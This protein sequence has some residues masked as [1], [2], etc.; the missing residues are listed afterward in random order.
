MKKF[1]S[2]TLAIVFVCAAAFPCFAKKAYKLEMPSTFT[3]ISSEND[4]YIWENTKTKSSIDTILSENGARLFY[5]GAD[6]A[7]QKSFTD[8][9]V[10]KL[11]EAANAN[12]EG[13]DYTISYNNV[14]FG[15]RKFAHCTGFEITTETT[16]KSLD[17]KVNVVF[18]SA[19]YFFSTKDLVVKI[20]CNLLSDEDKEAVEKMLNN[21]EMDGEI[22]T[23]DNVV[24]S[25]PP[26]W[27]LLI[28]V[29]IIAAVVVLIVALKKRRAKKS[30]AEA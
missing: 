18:E 3:E 21:F 6:S 2:F 28:P 19:F 12:S 23:E 8:D 30:D 22:L 17:G 13:K 26:Y 16:K 14:E 5:V 15:E 4:E 25:L 7:T 29:G 10:S 20:Q 27:T 9:F 1:L 11:V 24:D